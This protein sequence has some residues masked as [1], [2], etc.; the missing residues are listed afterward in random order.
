MQQWG[1]PG[2][3]LLVTSRDEVDIRQSL[4]ISDDQ[5]ISM[6]NVEI[7]KDIVNFVSYQLKNDPKLQ[8]WKERHSE[9]QD[10]LTEKAQG[11]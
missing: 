7:D 4:A 11:V 8:K 5:D 6:K 2:L 1:L 3:H 9:I 10:R